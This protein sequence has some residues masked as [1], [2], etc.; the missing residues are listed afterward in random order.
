MFIALKAKMVI[1]S[2]KKL[3]F[4]VATLRITFLFFR[5]SRAADIR[6]NSSKEYLASTLMKHIN[7]IKMTMRIGFLDNAVMLTLRSNFYICVYKN[8]EVTTTI[9]SQN[10]R[11][12]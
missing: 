7:D 3:S 8:R 1:R 5:D 4:S 2:Q 6:S 11:T 12:R 10:I 9:V